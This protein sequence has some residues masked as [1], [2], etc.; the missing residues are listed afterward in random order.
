MQEK[1]P[2]STVLLAVLACLLWSTAFVGVKIGLR[3]SDPFSFAGTRFMLSG[4]LLVPFWWRRGGR[5]S[6]IGAVFPLVFKVAVCQTFLLYALFYW[7]MTVVDGALA[8]I[9]VGASPLTAAVL[10]HFTLRDDTMTRGKTASLLLGL[11]GVAVISL[12]RK[13]WVSPAGFL[14][15]IGVLV[16][17]L[18]T[19]ASAYGNVLVV[20]EGQGIDPVLLN[21]AQIFLGGFFLLLFSLPFH[22]LPSFDLPAAYYGALL[23]LAFLSATAFSLWFVLLR[24]PG[25]KVSALNLWKFLIPVFGA[26]LSWLLLPD[27]S[28]RLWPVV[29]MVCIAFS[30]LCYHLAALRAA[31]A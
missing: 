7:G 26:L 28:P 30:I 17:F 19:I 31:R 9:V 6:A 15:F 2:F 14:E 24:R 20:R 29:G 27:E 21:S 8:A 23:W 22:G 25:V 10:A 11:V 5:F 4:L 12:S 3:Y 1:R 16:L 18:S 13:P